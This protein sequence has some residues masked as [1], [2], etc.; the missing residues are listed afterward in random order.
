MLLIQ[1][2]TSYEPDL[3]SL[4]RVCA[5]LTTRLVELSFVEET[6]MAELNLSY[7]GKNGSTDVLSFPLQPLPHAPLGDV[8]IAPEVARR[9]AE[10]LGHSQH[11]EVAVLLV[12]GILHLLGMD[13]ERD[14]GAMRLEEQRVCA[15]LGLPHALCLRE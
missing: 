1:N 4:E 11:E 10:A 9:Q 14:E 15:L 6:Q 5:A 3:S 7:R 2:E 8:V 13:H 12:H